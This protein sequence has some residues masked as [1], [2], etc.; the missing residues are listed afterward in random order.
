[1]QDDI[2]DVTNLGG[3]LLR[4]TD[5]NN[6]HSVLVRKR[7]G[8]Q[9]LSDKV[10]GADELHDGVALHERE[11]IDH[12]RAVEAFGEAYGGI[13]FRVE[14]VRDAELFEDAC[15]CGTA[16]L[17]DDVLDS[18]FLEVQDGEERGFK[19]LANA[20]DNAIGFGQRRD[21]CKLLFAGAVGN[22]CLRDHACDVLDLFGMRVDDHDVMTQRRQVTGKVVCRISKTDDNELSRSHGL[23]IELRT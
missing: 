16:R 8:F 5:G 20:D 22:D 15:V 10:L 13:A 14:N 17:R 18:Q 6:L 23:N 21:G 3:G 4:V 11:K 7:Q 2:G 1:M 12:V 9:S 19:I